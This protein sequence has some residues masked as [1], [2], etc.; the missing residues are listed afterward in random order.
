MTTKEGN[1]MQLSAITEMCKGLKDK[2]KALGLT[3]AEAALLIGDNS[4]E[5][6]V[7]QETYGRMTIEQLQQLNAGFVVLG[8]LSAGG[9]DLKKAARVLA[10]G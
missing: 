8:R 3:Q 5:T 10:C 9:V 1:Q 2:R 4:K 6:Y 7:R